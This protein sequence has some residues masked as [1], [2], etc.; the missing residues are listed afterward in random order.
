MYID[1]ERKWRSAQWVRSLLLQSE[2]LRA[3]IGDK[4]FPVVAP[5]NTEGAYI[6]VRRT[7]YGRERTK[8][9][10][11]RSI[12]SVTIAIY[13][14]DYDTGLLI[15]EVVDTLL[16]GGRGSFGVTPPDT[17]ATLDD[18]EEGYI[19]EKYYQLITYA[20]Q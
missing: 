12:C 19:D 3:I 5:L 4:V 10:D 20:I 15:A 16:D 18:S 8:D 1:N 14:D 2:G 17:M 7:D 11:Y 9:G 6:V 13:S